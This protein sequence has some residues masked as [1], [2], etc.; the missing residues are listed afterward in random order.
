MSSQS[1]KAQTVKSIVWNFT[2]LML[3]RGIAGLTTLLLAWFLAPEDFGLVAMMAVFLALSNVLVDA[4]LSQ[5][6]IRKQ[7]VSELDYDTAFFTNSILAF[8]VYAALF[9]VAPLVANFYDES[10]LVDLIRV[11]GIA[12][13]FSAFSMVQRTVL[14]RELKFKLQMQVSLPAAILSAVVAL[15]LAYLGYGVWALVAQI[16]LQALTNT[17]LYWRLRIWWPRLKFGWIE[18]KQLFS[19]SGY[20]LMAQSTNVPFK[21]MYVI[22]IAKI[23]AAPVAGL[24]FFAEKIKDLIIEQLVR[25]I[26][27]V[28]YPALARLQEEPE[29]LKAGY[30]QVITVM[31]F[32]LFPVLILMATFVESLFRLFLPEVWWPAA[33]FLQLMCLAA[34]LYPLH[35]TNLNILKV[36]GRADL[37]FYLGLFKKAVAIIIF[38]ISVRYGVI[39]VLFGQILASLLAYLPNSFYSKRLIG[40]TVYEQLADFMPSLILAGVIGYTLSWLVDILQWHEM[41]E[42]LVL[43]SLGI[44]F[45]LFGAW[46]LKLDA[47]KLACSLVLQQKERKDCLK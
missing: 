31:S 30:R 41:T 28:T 14:S 9:S 1:L 15:T 7:Q 40:Y 5:A 21:Y 27:T 10:Q 8:V 39:G 17:L 26:E 22:V 33:V 23:F 47:L 25:S 36:K 12:V 20:L 2:E 37:V 11:S 45:Y 19:F 4:G 29:R 6:L 32:L 42:L 16:L 13:I 24:Y 44:I 38:I 46:L 35:S 18:F 34:L 3:R 43:A